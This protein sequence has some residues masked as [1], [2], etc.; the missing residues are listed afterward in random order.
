MKGEEGGETERLEK[1][2]QPA[3][4]L[5]D[6]YMR[7][8]AQIAQ[9]FYERVA[10]V[11]EI[12]RVEFVTSF[13]P[14]D[15]RKPARTPLLLISA[16]LMSLSSARYRVRSGNQLLLNTFLV[17]RDR[18]GERDAA[19]ALDLLKILDALDAAV[20]DQAMGPAMQ[21]LEVYRRES[22]PLDKSVDSSLS[23][24]RTIYSTVVYPALARSRLVYRDQAGQ[25]QSLEFD[26]VATNGQT[27]ISRDQNDYERTLA[28]TLRYYQR[29]PKRRVELPLVLI[30]TGLKEQLE[31]MNGA[32]TEL[33]YYRD[34]EAGPTMT[35][36]WTNGVNFF[37]ERPGYW[38]GS[39]VLEE[40]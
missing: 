14:E 2:S 8:T 20:V 18:R 35:C 1:G 39:M 23:V 29:F 28:G 38:T 32:S 19:A 21:P 6:N 17:A 22:L 24:V 27:E 40:I 34:R 3:V 37:E 10:Q 30:P 31:E 5:P 9:A 13:S 16:H 36:L 15:I 26:L 33:V 7:Q 4:S 25:E 12:A 11:P